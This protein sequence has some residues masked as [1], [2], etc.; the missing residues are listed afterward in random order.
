MQALGIFVSEVETFYFCSATVTEEDCTFD[1]V[2]RSTPVGIS[3]CFVENGYEDEWFPMNVE[4]YLRVNEGMFPNEKAKEEFRRQLKSETGWMLDKQG[5]SEGCTIQR[6]MNAAEYEAFQLV[7]RNIPKKM[8]KDDSRFL[9]EDE[10]RNHL[11]KN[12]SGHLM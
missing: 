7:K 5:E 3:I 9:V 8:R 4:T 10:P 11:F 12:R 6:A 2:V 1:F